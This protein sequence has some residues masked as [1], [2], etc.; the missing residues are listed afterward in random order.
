MKL[1]QVVDTFGQDDRSEERTL[2][3]RRGVLRIDGDVR[4]YDVVVLDL[5]R[6]GC[7]IDTKLPIAEGSRIEIG[8]ANIGRVR[9][10]AVWQGVEGLGCVFDRALPSGAITAAQGPTNVLSLSGE[11]MANE[12]AMEPYKLRVRTRLMVLGGACV[13]SWGV[14]AAAVRVTV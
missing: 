3:E 14:I 4:P 12:R 7:R 5:T 6:E 2:L 11:D 8:L 1:A 9:A 10:T 13:L